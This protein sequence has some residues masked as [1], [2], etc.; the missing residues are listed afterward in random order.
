MVWGRVWKCFPLGMGIGS[1]CGE[2]N[3]GERTEGQSG[4]WLKNGERRIEREDKTRIVGVINV[5][6]FSPLSE[7][8]YQIALKK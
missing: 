7:A 1:C 6:I 2:G 4:K 3:A 8:G 5:S